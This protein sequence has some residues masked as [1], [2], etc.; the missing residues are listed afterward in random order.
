MTE[1][2]LTGT[3]SL[4]SIN[5]WVLSALILLQFC[6]FVMRGTSCLFLTIIKLMLSTS[7]YLDELLNIDNP[8]F[9]KNG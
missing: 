7:R 1:I 8:Y 3:L 9:E 2:L 6:F 5:Q 4:N